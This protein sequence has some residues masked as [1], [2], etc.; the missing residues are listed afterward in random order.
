M[1]MQFVGPL[2][3][4]SKGDHVA[5]ERRAESPILRFDFLDSRKNTKYLGRA[6]KLLEPRDAVEYQTETELIWLLVYTYEVGLFQC[7]GPHGT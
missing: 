1:K 5:G 6:I 2:N 4:F 3:R 7:G